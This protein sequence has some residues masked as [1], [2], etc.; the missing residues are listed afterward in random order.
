VHG[1]GSFPARVVC[2]RHFAVRRRRRRYNPSEGLSPRICCH[3]FRATGIT[4]Y[5]EGG[6]TIEK[7]QAIACQES[8]K[9]TKLYARTSRPDRPRRDRK[10]QELSGRQRSVLRLFSP[11]KCSTDATC[12]TPA[13]GT[14]FHGPSRQQCSGRL[15][16]RSA[17]LRTLPG[18]SQ[19][20]ARTRT[21]VASSHQDRNAG[22]FL[23]SHS[24]SAAC[25]SNSATSMRSMVGPLSP[26]CRMSSSLISRIQTTR[27][28]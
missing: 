18:A 11:I 25:D 2:P 10:D 22:A 27:W 26:T 7:A 21:G 9:T 13:K 23:L 28:R 5:L 17:P 4:A 12:R 16:E 15:Q 1:P 8:L 14:P 19:A 6:G 24:R 3:T 20:E